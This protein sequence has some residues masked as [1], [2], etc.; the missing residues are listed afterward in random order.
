MLKKTLLTVGIAAVSMALGACISPPHVQ[1]G[2]MHKGHLQTH[3]Q[4]GTRELGSTG[5]QCYFCA[6][7]ERDSDGDGVLDRVDYCPHTPR[8]VKVDLRGCALD[9]DRDGVLN[10]K[11]DCPNTPQGATVDVVGCWVIQDLHFHTAKWDIQTRSYHVLNEVAAILNR[12]AGL[13][14]E[15]QGHTDNQGAHA[16]N[17]ALS[18]KR[19]NAVKAFLV[20]KGIQAHR[21]TTRGFGFDQ[22]VA[23]NETSA[24]RALNRRV[25]LAVQ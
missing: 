18:H 21:M 4:T 19:A 3:P 24:G 11:D 20:R 22:P 8:G 12:H 14:I 5:T 25:M 16:W 7:R 15:I 6:G 23:S 10:H 1:D 17:M 9:S 2:W 13:N